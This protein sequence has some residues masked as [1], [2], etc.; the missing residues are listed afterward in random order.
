MSRRR[1]H[2]FEGR[3]TRQFRRMLGR[4]GEGEEIEEDPSSKVTCIQHAKRWKGALVRSRG[5]GGQ[6]LAPNLS[7]MAPEAP[8]PL[9]RWP[10]IY[11]GLWARTAHHQLQ[12]ADAFHV[13]RG[14]SCTGS[15]EHLQK[16]KQRTRGKKAWKSLLLFISLS[17]AP[18][19]CHL[20]CHASFFFFFFF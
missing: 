12:L 6:V 2:Q 17:P 13:C 9:L 8:P 16:G 14:A 10:L 18:P 20:H 7:A 11:L 4:P 1:F 5:P 3:R 15:A 19:P